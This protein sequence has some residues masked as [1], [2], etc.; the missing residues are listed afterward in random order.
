MGKE[1]LDLTEQRLLVSNAQA[2]QLCRPYG[3]APRFEEREGTRVYDIEQA[4]TNLNQVQCLGRTEHFDAD[5]AR[6]IP[7]LAAYGLPF[8]PEQG[9]AENTSSSDFREP[10]QHQLDSM[11]ASLADEIWERL[12]HC[13]QQDL[14][15]YDYVSALIEQRDAAGFPTYLSKNI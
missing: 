3:R 11:K 14:E 9:L 15:L 12:L 10:M 4:I 1:K 8:D 6:F 7:I 13:N 5:V 2:N